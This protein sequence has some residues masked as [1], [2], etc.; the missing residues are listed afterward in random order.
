[1]P[2]PAPVPRCY[3]IAETLQIL[4]AAG[5]QEYQRGVEASFLPYGGRFLVRGG[6][7]QPLEQG[8]QPQRVV[9]IEFPSADALRRWHESEK[10]ATLR[11]KRRATALTRSFMVDGY[12]P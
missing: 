5:F 8:W 1:V 12:G 7:V 11:A 3:L 2:E 4:D 9:V 6:E 10:Y